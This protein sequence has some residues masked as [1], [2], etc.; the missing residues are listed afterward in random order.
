M[1]ILAATLK[2]IDMHTIYFYMLL[3]FHQKNI[4]YGKSIKESRYLGLVKEIMHNLLDYEN[5]FKDFLNRILSDKMTMR[6][7]YF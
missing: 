6:E 4:A 1:N 3:D 5:D 2:V 7:L